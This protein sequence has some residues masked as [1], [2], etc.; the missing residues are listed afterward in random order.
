MRVILVLGN[1][2]IT[3]QDQEVEKIKT[4]SEFISGNLEFADM[5]EEEKVFTLES[6]EFGEEELRNAIEYLRN[7]NYSPPHYKKISSDNIDSELNTE[8]ERQLASKYRGQ[9]DIKRLLFAA[10]YLQIKSLQLFALVLLGV[11]YKVNENKH[12]SLNTVKAF[13]G[14]KDEYDMN[15]EKEIKERLPNYGEKN[16]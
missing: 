10:K 6:D 3:L 16:S 15:V 2:R 11:S 14:I 8:S 13:H 5:D 7:H 4:C 12:D 1:T 9:K